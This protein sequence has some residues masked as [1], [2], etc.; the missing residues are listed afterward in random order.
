[1][2]VSKRQLK[3]IIREEK[4]NLS[5]VS[6]SY[7]API[8]APGATFEERV[9]MSDV[10]SGRPVAS[11]VSVQHGMVVVEFSNSFILHLDGLDTRDLAQAL[12]NAEQELELN[13][14]RR[15]AP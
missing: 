13:D 3:R 5:R 7:G 1:M 11:R 4:A 6:E 2:R 15:T 8:T 12:L 9:M 10:D 14:M